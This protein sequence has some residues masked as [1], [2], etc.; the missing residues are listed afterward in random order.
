M[1]VPN[2]VPAEVDAWL[3]IRVDYWNEVRDAL[4]AALGAM[5]AELEADNPTACTQMEWEAEPLA[6]IRAVLAREGGYH[7]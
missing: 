7:V 3:Q 1:Y 4:K 6:T 2:I 5:E